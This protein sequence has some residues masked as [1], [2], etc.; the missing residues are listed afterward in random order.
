MSGE[1]EATVL[2]RESLREHET[3]GEATIESKTTAKKRT[4]D[5]ELRSRT[6]LGSQN[7]ELVS[8]RGLNQA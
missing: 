6:S 3:L 8:C 1:R 5:V 7:Y 2:R 4:L